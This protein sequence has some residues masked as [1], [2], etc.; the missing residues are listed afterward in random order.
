MPPLCVINRLL[1]ASSA[2]ERARAIL[3]AG[4]LVP[5]NLSISAVFRASKSIPAASALKPTFP[6]AAFPD[7]VQPT[8]LKSET[9]KAYTSCVVIE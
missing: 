3:W 4:N 9:L 8:V 2:E 6:N 7:A 5:E 1:S